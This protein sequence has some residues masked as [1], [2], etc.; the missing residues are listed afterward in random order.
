M[1]T[2]FANDRDVGAVSNSE[3]LTSQIDFYTLATTVPLSTDDFELNDAGRDLIRLGEIIGIQAQPVVTGLHVLP[4]SVQANYGLASGSKATLKSAANFAVLAGAAV[5]NTGSSVITGD[6]GAT[7][8]ITPGPWSVTGT[9]HTVND[10]AT[11]QALI[12]GHAAYNYLSVLP[13]TVLTGD[14]GGKTLT[15]GVYSYPSSAGLTGTLTLDF[16]GLSDQMIVIIAGSTL[17]TA[18][19]S[20]VNVINSNPSNSVFWVLGSSATLGTTTSFAGN[21]I[22]QVSVTLTTGATIETGSALALTGSVSLDSNIIN[23]DASATA[24]VYLLKFMIEHTNAWINT[25][26]SG[27]VAGT[28]AYAL[29]NETALC[30]LPVSGAS[31]VMGTNASLT[32]SAIL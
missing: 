9:V 13:S 7:S 25:D 21:I 22:A 8:A 16:Q 6:V 3:H 14:L 18:S 20:V 28:L 30:P 4:G 32:F 26:V 2:S 19:A 17:T 29:V 31:L 5:T 24:T 27:T 1:T 10:A 15:P 23:S 11:I 12:D